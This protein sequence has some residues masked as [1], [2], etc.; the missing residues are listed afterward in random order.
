MLRGQCDGPL[1]FALQGSGLMCPSGQSGDLMAVRMKPTKPPSFDVAWCATQG[2]EG[3][4]MAT[5]VNSGGGSATVWSAGSDAAS[6]QL[7]AFNS[8]TGAKLWSS[9]ALGT[10]AR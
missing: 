7:Y 6:N 5:G 3:S 9:G 10:V 8:V 4:P 2:G 1:P